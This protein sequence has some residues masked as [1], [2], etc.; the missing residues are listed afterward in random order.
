MRDPGNE[1][2]LECVWLLKGILIKKAAKIS[3]VTITTNQKCVWSPVYW[4]LK[5]I[6][7]SPVWGVPGE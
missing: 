4:L 3:V 6:F 7:F 2:D 5:K 1:V